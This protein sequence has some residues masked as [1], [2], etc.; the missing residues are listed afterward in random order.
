L[1]ELSG[2]VYYYRKITKS[3]QSKSEP[4]T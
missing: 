1:C 4:V 2:N 3:L